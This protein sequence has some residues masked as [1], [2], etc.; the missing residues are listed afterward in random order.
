MSSVNF[1]ILLTHITGFSLWLKLGM[2]VAWL[3]GGCDRDGY[4]NR[5]GFLVTLPFLLI[6]YAWGVAVLFVL[7]MVPVLILFFTPL[8]IFIF[9]NSCVESLRTLF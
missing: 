9:E 5:W 1:V 7:L 6:G 4:L 3:L 8:C 2:I